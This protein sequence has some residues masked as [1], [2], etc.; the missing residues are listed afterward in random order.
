MDFSLPRTVEILE[1]TPG[2]L[3]SLLS[4]L[5]E[6]WTG[7][8]EG[9]GTWSPFDVVGHLIH[10]DRTNWIPRARTILGEGLKIFPP[11]DRAAMLE[12]DRGKPLPD[13]LD[14]FDRVRDDSLETLAGMKIGKEEL[15]RKGVHPD[16]GEVTLRQLL[17][18]WST[19]DLDHL[20]QITRVTARQYGSAV[21]PWKSFLR[22]LK[23]ASQFFGRPACARAAARRASAG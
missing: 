11:F 5:S 2:V 9:P 4:G 23:E 13:L 3:R 15:A 6:E 17:A 18:T 12:A 8:N 22:V 16:F 7:G 10:A 14:E 20:H 1:R 19:H 21:G